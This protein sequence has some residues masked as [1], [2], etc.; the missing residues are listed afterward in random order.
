M[1]TGNQPKTIL[2][3][4]INASNTSPTQPSFAVFCHTQ[5]SRPLLLKEA[6]EVFFA[7]AN[8][9][10]IYQVPRQKNQ[11]GYWKPNTRI[12]LQDAAG[13]ANATNQSFT[14][15]HLL[16]SSVTPKSKKQ[17]Q[18]TCKDLLIQKGSIWPLLYMTDDGYAEAEALW[19]QVQIWP[20]V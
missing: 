3:L 14:A 17:A 12:P 20:L 19:K 10:I 4:V 6:R 11:G 16:Q 9:V 15:L 18:S 2:L 13:S 5:T 7:Y 1:G 8:A